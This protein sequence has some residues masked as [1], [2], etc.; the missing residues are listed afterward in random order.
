M[1]S[2][3]A[4]QGGQGKK[5]KSDD[6]SNIDYMYI[7][8]WPRFIVLTS[9]DE[10]KII[11]KLSPFILEKWLKSTVG[12]VRNVTKMKS[13]SLLVECY[14][15]QQSINLLS[16]TTILET[17]ISATPHRTLNYSKGIIRDRDRTLIELPEEEI[18]QELKPQ[19]ITNVKRFSIKKQGTIIKLNTYLFTFE[20]PSIPNTINVGPYRMKVD[21][22][23]ANPTRCFQCQKFGHGKQSCRGHAKCYRCSEE[24]HDGLT[25]DKP[26][27]CSN[28]NLDHMSSSKECPVYLKEREIQK[29]KIEKNISYLD[30]RRQVSISNDS[31]QNSKASYASAA[32]RTYTSSTTQTTLA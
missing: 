17:E 1:D 4:L 18:C 10:N 31:S 8:T 6:N 25:C 7:N 14:R 19:G 5:R 2:F 12:E 9:K 29:I 20:S 26:V 21:Q 23:I 13:G 15:Q 32:K 28:C 3:G 11:T 30:A 27:K 16:A 24:G 22:Y